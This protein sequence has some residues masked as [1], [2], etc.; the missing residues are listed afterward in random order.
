MRILLANE[1]GGG[2]GHSAILEPLARALAK[3]DCDAIIALPAATLRSL[4]ARAVEISLLTAPEVPGPSN[5]APRSPFCTFAD[6]LFDAG[7]ADQEHLLRKVRAWREL[8]ERT[9][10]DLVVINHAPFLHLASIDT[11]STTW[12]GTGFEIPPPSE[13]FPPLMGRVPQPRST[14]LV[15]RAL[16][17]AQRE[18]G[19]LEAQR[20]ED[21]F[22]APSH[23]IITIPEL[24]PYSAP[25]ARDC[26]GPLCLL[27]VARRANTGRVFAY[28]TAASANTRDIICGLA[29]AQVPARAVVLGQQGATSDR[30]RVANVELTSAPVP[31]AD[32]LGECS[33]LVHHGG[34]SL[35]QEA[36][37]AGV[38][39]LI[40]PRFDE[41]QLN[42]RAIER[43]GAGRVRT[44]PPVAWVSRTIR[45]MITDDVLSERCANI[46]QSLRTR[47]PHGSLRSVAAHCRE[48]ATR[49]AD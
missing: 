40:L 4:E 42:G 11:V 43:L 26:A 49:K 18:L 48:R 10:P 14:Q 32:A 47:F 7:F 46:G 25:Q 24:D 41:Q 13:R 34:L 37:L 38:P 8:L 9:T 15:L 30:S 21:I 31:I 33:L 5:I 36:L 27:E 22:P 29:H 17:S 2:L 28:L 23:Y 45:S 6:G 44:N 16:R 35:T 12:V 3:L 39:Q 20:L 19:M 1:L